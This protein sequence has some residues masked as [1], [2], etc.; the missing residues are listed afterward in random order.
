M[1]KIVVQEIAVEEKVERYIKKVWLKI[2][3]LEI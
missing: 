1:T 2:K 3:R